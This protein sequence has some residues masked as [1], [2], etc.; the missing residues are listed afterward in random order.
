MLSPR[1]EG[2]AARRRL[3]AAGGRRRARRRGR[4][5]EAAQRTPMS[6][7]RKVGPLQAAERAAMAGMGS[8]CA[9]PL[10][11]NVLAKG[12]EGHHPNK[13]RRR[14][15]AARSPPAAASC[16]APTGP[17]HAGRP[18]TCSGTTRTT[19][20]KADP[21]APRMVQPSTRSASPPRS[22]L[23]D[24]VALEAVRRQVRAPPSP[25]P[26]SPRAMRLAGQEAPISLNPTLSK[27]DPPITLIG[28]GLTGVGP[29]HFGYALAQTGAI[30]GESPR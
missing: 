26:V 15:T 10:S 24:G 8:T 13:A 18:P 2:V 5:C 7:Y 16:T 9:A 12:N 3:A 19:R 1:A 27:S 28:P 25:A 21:G 6:T 17:T 29:S 14:C 23:R 30:Y 4:T 22:E 20:R 11:G